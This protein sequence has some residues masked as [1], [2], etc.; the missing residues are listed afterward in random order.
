M[1]AIGMALDIVSLKAENNIVILTDSSSVVSN[2]HVHCYYPI[3]SRLIHRILDLQITGKTINLCWIPS[4]IG[5][6]GN[7]LGHV[8]AKAGSG[9]R[10][11]PILI[12]YS[13]WRGVIRDALVGIWKQRSEMCRDK[14]RHQNKSCG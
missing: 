4:H 1:H 14:L 12:N 9:R 5:I 6:E 10:E 2:F 13:G 11:E 3:I 8:A 7:E